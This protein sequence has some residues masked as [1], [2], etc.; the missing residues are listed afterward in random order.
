MKINII[1]EF[2]SILIRFVIRVARDHDLQLLS[3]VEQVAL[4]FCLIYRKNWT[5]Q[6]CIVYPR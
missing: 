6:T 3:L 2:V 1:M 5:S 4:G